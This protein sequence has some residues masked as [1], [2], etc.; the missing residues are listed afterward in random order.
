MIIYY[1]GISGNVIDL[2][3][4][5]NN[6]AKHVLLSYHYRSL[7]NQKQM[8]R[9]RNLGLHL[10]VDSGAYSA[11]K[12]GIDI[13]IDEYI[14]YLKENCIGKFINLDVVGDPEKTYFNQ[15]YMEDKGL[16]PVPVHHMGSDL[17]YL[18][19]YEKE[20]YRYICLGGS[21]GASKKSR[22]QYFDQCFENF[23]N[24]LFHGLGMTD[25]ELMTKYPWMSVD[26]TTW[27]VGRKYCQVITEEGRISIP[28]DTPMSEKIGKNVKFFRELERKSI[29]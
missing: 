7:Y 24:L 29:L 8:R 4:A 20:G 9:F 14:A 5:V 1:A 18:S 27:L 11:W 10:F 3:T 13:D 21:V 15:K 28:K 22:V 19:Q 2:H 26:S 6:G 17:T 12:V 16:N 25:I 23:P